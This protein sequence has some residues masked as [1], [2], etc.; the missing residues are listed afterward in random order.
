M[1]SAPATLEWW[2]ARLEEAPARLELPR[3]SGTPDTAV[4][5][6]LP[7]DADRGDV[8]AVVAGLLARDSI[9]GQAA[10]TVGLDGCWLP[11]VINLADAP[12]RYVARE[13]CLAELAESLAHS[14]DTAELVA[15][16]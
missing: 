7:D 4:D 3:A 14:V 11:V 8:L 6:V 1:T 15:A 5:V 9:A 2:R 13:R 16:V 12:T 10:V